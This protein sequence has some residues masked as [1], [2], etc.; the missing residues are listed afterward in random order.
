MF[1]FVYNF[2][3]GAVYEMFCTVLCLE[4]SNSTAR[5]WKLRY[6]HRASGYTP[7][8]ES[9]QKSGFFDSSADGRNH[10]SCMCF[11]LFPLQNQEAR[12]LFSGFYTPRC[13]SAGE[14]SVP[15]QFLS[16]KQMLL[17]PRGSELCGEKS[18]CCGMISE[19]N[20]SA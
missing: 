16:Q 2:Q 13:L 11:P 9:S 15:T 8:T 20:P 10:A 19:S 4:T 6:T 18:G 7:V 12:N 1:I 14:L 3:L 5:R 17:I